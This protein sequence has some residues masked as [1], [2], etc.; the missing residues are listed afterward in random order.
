MAFLSL[1]KLSILTLD[2]IRC[3][4]GVFKIEVVRQSTE[5]FVISQQAQCLRQRGNVHEFRIFDDRAS[6]LCCEFVTVGGGTKQLVELQN[7]ASQNT[8]AWA[9]NHRFIER[10]PF[11]VRQFALPLEEQPAGFMHL[12]TVVPSRLI[13]PLFHWAPASASGFAW[14]GNSSIESSERFSQLHVQLPQ[15]VK[16][17]PL[18]F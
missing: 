3:F 4:I 9:E 16:H 2:L 13:F 6:S 7:E 11:F 18:L 15:E 10:P 12:P 8:E 5:E 14:L 17:T 1:P